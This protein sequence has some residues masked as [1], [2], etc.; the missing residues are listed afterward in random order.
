MHARDA[1]ARAAVA[2]GGEVGQEVVRGVRPGAVAGCVD[3]AAQR[4]QRRADAAVDGVAPERAAVGGAG[5]ADADRGRDA[6]GAELLDAGEDRG[7][8]EAELDHQPRPQALAAQQVELG[9]DRFVE[10]GGADAAMALRVDGEPDFAQAVALQE[11][12]AQEVEA[13]VERA[14]R[15]RSPPIT[16]TRRTPAPP[17]SRRRT[18]SSRAWPLTLRAARCGTGTSPAFASRTAPATRPSSES[19]GGKPR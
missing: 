11:A 9:Q 1:E 17:A 7:R 3:V 4:R 12:G 8:R 14:G 18:S 10:G 16:S 5:E 6:L 13:G 19:P 2:G 15:S